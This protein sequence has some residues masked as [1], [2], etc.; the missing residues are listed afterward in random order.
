L[1][2]G[3]TMSPGCR[4]IAK[5]GRKSPLRANKNRRWPVFFKRIYFTESACSGIS[6]PALVDFVGIY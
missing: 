1:G 2:G 6:K 4:S 5:A 3:A